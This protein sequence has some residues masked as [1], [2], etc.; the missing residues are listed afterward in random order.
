MSQATT[1]TRYWHI[2]ARSP[3]HTL[4]IRLVVRLRTSEQHRRNKRQCIPENSAGTTMACVCVDRRRKLHHEL[5]VPP[6]YPAV[7]DD[8]FPIS[9]KLTISLYRSSWTRRPRERELMTTLN[10]ISNA[11]ADFVIS[12]RLFVISSYHIHEADDRASTSNRSS[13]L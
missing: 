11:S 1:A 7:S 12:S 8:T 10:N 2:V 5:S 4:L 9:R 13:I 3:G 6:R